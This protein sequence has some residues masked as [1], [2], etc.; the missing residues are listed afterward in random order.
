[1]NIEFYLEYSRKTHIDK[2]FFIK[3][4]L[5]AG[6]WLSLPD[7][8]IN[9]LKELDTEG[10]EYAYLLLAI[11]E[12]AL[13]DLKYWTNI[14]I[15]DDIII[16][17]KILQQEYLENN[18]LD[19]SKRRLLLSALSN[20]FI[21]VEDEVFFRK[22]LNQIFTEENI[23]FMKDT[24]R[25]VYDAL[26]YIENINTNIGDELRLVKD[27][28]NED[29]K[30]LYRGNSLYDTSHTQ[31]SALK[32][33]SYFDSSQV[34]YLKNYKIINPAFCLFSEEE[35]DNQVLFNFDEN[36]LNLEML[37]NNI[38]I[39]KIE[40]FDYVK[41]ATNISRLLKE[42]RKREQMFFEK[43]YTHDN[44]S[45]IIKN[46][47]SDITFNMIWSK[48]YHDYYINI[49][50]NKKIKFNVVELI[51]L[52]QQLFLFLTIYSKLNNNICLRDRLTLSNKDFLMLIGLK[53]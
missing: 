17:K 4:I 15:L 46:K 52:F 47:I 32:A 3:N 40:H 33:I 41:L 5:E 49:G 48:K 1:M 24:L 20:T 42:Y 30:I 26:I 22:V 10:S 25:N 51:N 8:V 27:N 45:L 23:Y 12:K 16:V 18:K 43:S 11:R 13:I 6:K 9:K 14:T 19:E 35:I 44:F 53:S 39:L 38:S 31:I 21:A 34:E 2:Y 7:K 29:R 37:Y 28:D 50:K 36:G